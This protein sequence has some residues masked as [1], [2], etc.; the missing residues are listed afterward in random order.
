[1]PSIEMLVEDLPP[2]DVP[3]PKKQVQK[4]YMKKW[5]S[6]FEFKGWFYK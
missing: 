4:I 3:P 5:E 1:M 2:V 6:G